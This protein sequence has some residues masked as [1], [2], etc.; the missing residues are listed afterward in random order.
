MGC[1]RFGVVLAAVLA[2]AAGSVSGQVLT[3]EVEFGGEINGQ[4]IEASGSGSLERHGQG[5]NFGTIG[6]R[7]L[8][9]GFQPLAVDALLTNVCPNGFQAKGD[10]DNLW[11][12]GGGNYLIERTF[13]WIGYP[14]S[15]VTSTAEVTF[16]QDAQHLT[17]TM[18]FSG[19]YAGPTDLVAIEDYSVLWLP[20]STEG[21]VFEAGTAL[22]RRANDELLVV[23]FATRY[24]GLRDSLGQAQFGIG[25]FAT[26]FDGQTLTIDWDGYFQVPGPGALALIAPAAIGLAARRRRV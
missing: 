22:V 25:E 20:G 23:Q 8:P 26:T 7:E 9:D 14:G 19:N 12:L 2:A 15:I 13:Q 3:F 5:S 17:S 24:Y 18:H 1:M 16:D 6:F 10:T 4:P 11:D 21:E